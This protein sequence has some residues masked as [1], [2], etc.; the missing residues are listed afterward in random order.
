MKT[1]YKLTLLIFLLAGAA[2]AAQQPVSVPPDAEDNQHKR[3]MVVIDAGH[4]GTDTGVNENGTLEKDLNLSLAKLIADKLQKSGKNISV[5]LTRNT[6]TLL[7]QEQRA[8]TANN[9]KADLYISIHC[10]YAQAHVDGFKIYYFYGENEGPEP[11]PG[12]LTR[13]DDVQYKY[14]G[15]SEKLAETMD[16]YMHAG[17]IPEDSADTAGEENNI[18]PLGDRGTLGTYAAPLVGLDMPA[19]LIEAGNMNNKNNLIAL[20]D[21]KMQNIIAYH[22]KEGIVNYLK[23]R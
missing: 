4:G 15:P 11:N 12:E 17:L 22:I 8:G 1:L 10:D 6:D 2:H 19:V 14:E 3:Y 7:K 5:V 23:G 20:K 13:W 18:V 16:Q 21:I 9:K